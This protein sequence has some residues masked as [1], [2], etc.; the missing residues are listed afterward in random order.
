MNV[1]ACMDELGAALAAISDLRVTPYSAKK[2]N[3]PAAVVAWP[4]IDYDKAF[5]RGADRQ[6]F[7]LILLVGNVDARSSRDDLAEYLDGSGPRSVKTAVEAHEATA[8]DSA[9]VVRAE[10]SVMTVAAVEYLAATL[11]VDIIGRGA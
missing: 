5:A 9:R 8:Y 10:V 3:P 7:P 11:Y 6:E 4:E 1:A 2:I